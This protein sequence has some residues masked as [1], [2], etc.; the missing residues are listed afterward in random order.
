MV[1]WSKNKKPR[2]K[3][4]GVSSKN[5]HP[6]RIIDPPGAISFSGNHLSG[7]IGPKKVKAKIRTPEIAYSQ[8]NSPG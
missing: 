3:L 6:G 4:L 2:G 8:S 1:V 5:S 7:R